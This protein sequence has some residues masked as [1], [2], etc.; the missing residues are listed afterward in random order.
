MKKILIILLLAIMLV[1]CS[2]SKEKKTTALDYFK[3]AEGTQEDVNGTYGL[4]NDKY[5]FYIDNITD[6]KYITL[7]LKVTDIDDNN[8]FD[9]NLN[10]I[11][12]GFYAARAVDDEPSLYY[13]TDLDY[14]NLDISI[15]YDYN[16]DGVG[17]DLFTNITKNGGFTIL[18]VEEVA[19][20]EY[21]IAILS[22]I[23]DTNYYYYDIAY[24]KEAGNA[25]F[26]REDANYKVA[27][28]YDNKTITINKIDNGNL[29]EEKTITMP[30]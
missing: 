8:L 16:Y 20:A 14:Y 13:T 1:G 15:D 2:G 24:D 7:H 12:P 9:D 29:K 18:E 10:M 28:D 19:K 21:A 5:F 17:T 23:L 6:D 22:N 4:Y 25:Q 30:F 11:R 3:T 26:D 27:V